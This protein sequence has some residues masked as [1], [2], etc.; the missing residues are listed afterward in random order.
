MTNLTRREV[1]P[2]IIVGIGGVLFAGCG[3]GGSSSGGSA[4]PPG[5]GGGGGGGGTTT[6]GAATRA[7]TNVGTNNNYPGMGGALF[8]SVSSL[9]GPL[10]YE[11]WQSYAAD[12]A[13]V[14]TG[15]LIVWRNVN[16]GATYGL[17]A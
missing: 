3:G 5:G 6:V 15:S 10:N 1:L 4:P 16:T 17:T 12:G 8:T 7:S 11:A 2:V 14:N 13:P 9:S